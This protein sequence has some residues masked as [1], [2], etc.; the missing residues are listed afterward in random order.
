ME[1]IISPAWESGCS[2]SVGKTHVCGLLPEAL[3]QHCGNALTR[4]V[5]CIAFKSHKSDFPYKHTLCDFSL[6]PAISEHQEPLKI[7]SAEGGEVLQPVFTDTNST[8]SQSG[9]ISELQPC[10]L[11]AHYSSLHTYTG[12]EQG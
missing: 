6:E 10:T 8:Q 2:F 12:I 11:F 9:P 7:I 1:T 5:T 4:K 3:L